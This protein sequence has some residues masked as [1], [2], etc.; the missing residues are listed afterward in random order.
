MSSSK[1]VE[2][3]KSGSNLSEREGETT[4]SSVEALIEAIEED[5]EFEEFD[6]AKWGT[7]EEDADDVQ[8]WKDNW[9]DDDID[10]EFTNHLRAELERD[11]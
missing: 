1:E 2:N 7:E 11:S 10:D 9:D 8:Q 6:P 4:K 3:T 5:D